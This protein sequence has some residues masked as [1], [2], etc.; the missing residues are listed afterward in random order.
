M[1]RFWNDHVERFECVK[2]VANVE[3]VKPV[4][5]VARV[6]IMNNYVEYVECFEYVGCVATCGFVKCVKVVGCLVWKIFELFSDVE[7][8]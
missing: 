5:V 6:I 8:I 1:S 4:E 2:F 3:H 7:D